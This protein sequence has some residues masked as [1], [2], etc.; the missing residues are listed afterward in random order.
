MLRTRSRLPPVRRRAEAAFWTQQSRTWDERLADPRIAGRVDELAGWLAGALAPPGGGGGDGGDGG[1]ARVVVADLGCGTGTHASA[2]ASRS[3]RASV[4]GVERSPG[5][6]AMARA[7][8]VAV[9]QADL[10]DGLPLATA[11]CGGALSVYSLQFLDA[12]A[13]LAEAHRVLRAGA[14]IVVEVPRSDG[15]RRP[16]VG[17]SLSRRFRLAQ[18]VNRTAAAFGSRVGLVRTFT[19]VELDRV[20]VGAGFEVVEHR[21]TERSV[22]A[23]A[24]AV[25]TG[26]GAAPGQ[27]GGRTSPS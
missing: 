12:G 23:L 22:A 7:K 25:A 21:D 11:S 17:A 14:P 6:V 26:R 8:G 19:A 16:E 9:V 20:L 15:G 1:G 18:R 13:V 4:V 3:G 27:P 5:M 10:G 2:L 24:R